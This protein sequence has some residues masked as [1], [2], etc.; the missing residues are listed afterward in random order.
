M[1]NDKREALMRAAGF[2]TPT[3]EA[4]SAE[5]V[6]VKPLDVAKIA[7]KHLDLSDAP[8]ED[9]PHLQT[10]LEEAIKEALSSHPA[11]AQGRD[12]PVA[13][14]WRFRATGKTVGQWN[15][16]QDG[17]KP[18]LRGADYEVEE[19]PLYLGPS[20][21]TSL[22]K[23]QGSPAPVSAEAGTHP[24]DGDPEHEAL[25]LINLLHDD[26][27]MQGDILGAM[28][29]VQSRILSALEPAQGRDGPRVDKHRPSFLP[30]CMPRWAY[31]KGWEDA[32]EAAAQWLDA[33]ASRIASS[34]PDN[35]TCTDEEG[36]D[37]QAWDR[38]RHREA[39]YRTD[40]AV[41]RAL[42]KEG[43]R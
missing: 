9:Y 19:R 20:D 30:E 26:N 8:F 31:A 23:A 17:R 36:C 22:Q 5:A 13:W 38:S 41:I 43:G 39:M 37:P 3:T 28:S 34:R 11:P 42:T 1:T 29:R 12:E 21:A 16:W 25:Y 14:Q 15:E 18:D 24:L 6:K 32:R 7:R 33:Q 10:M 4:V 35:P 2:A 27:L 40:A